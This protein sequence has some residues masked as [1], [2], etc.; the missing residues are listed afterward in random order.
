MN[1]KTLVSIFLLL[2]T[3]F[4]LAYDVKTVDS[5]LIVKFKSSKALRNK[6]NMPNILQF[7]ELNVDFGAF[8]LLKA[9]SQKGLNEIEASLKSD[10]SVDYV[11]PNYIY[12]KVSYRP[13]DPMFNQLWGL[14]NGGNNEPA[15]RGGNTQTPGVKGSDVSA[16]KAWKLTKGARTIKIAVIDTGVDYNHEDLKNNMWVNTL[17]AN[18]KEGV[19]DD[20]N[21]FVDDIYGYDFSNKDGDPMDGNG[22]GTHCAGT[23]GAEHNNALGVAGVMG[24]VSIM[25]IKFLSDAGSGSTADAIE[26]INYASKMNVDIMSNSWGGGGH[27]KALEEAIK[28]ANDKGIFFIAA[29][30]NSGENNNNTPHYPSSYEVENVI[31]VAAHNFSDDLAEFS[32]YGSKS[33]H[34]AAPGKNILSTTPNN[35]YA[36][37]SGT[38]MATPHVA[39][40]VGLYLAHNGQSEVLATKKMLMDSAVYNDNYGRKIISGGRVDAYH[41]LM[42]QKMPRPQRPKPEDWKKIDIQTF[43]SDHPYKASRNVI[44]TFK[45]T[46]AKFI[47]VRIKKLDLEPG[48]DFLHV[49]DAKGRPVDSLTGK[50]DDIASE[51]VVG[52]EL[53]IKFKTDETVQRWGFLIEQLEYID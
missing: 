36:V 16:L 15:G 49:L 41:F 35:Q 22:H 10:P 48:F 28:D 52:D 6:L 50:L 32:C 46:G 30:G 45:K 27:S 20:Q 14:L 7:R 25:A 3:N 38:S 53:T 12:H 1:F 42:N 2:S 8:A 31:S 11:E 17:E 47:R 5:E 4:L 21:G 34:V 44:K 24:D 23:I 13:N 33:V 18:G 40:V 51:Y 19:D 9:K 37:Y 39:G 43:E 29:A 26:S